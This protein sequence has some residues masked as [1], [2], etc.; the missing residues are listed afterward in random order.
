ML[1][2]NEEKFY[3]VKSGETLSGLAARF[4]LSA[5]RVAAENHLNAP[6]WVGQVLFLP[7]STGVYT[8]QAGDTKTL[9]C[10]SEEAYA[11]CNGTQIFYPGM[12][13]QL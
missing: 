5:Y 4:G 1:R 13:V 8:V 6:L 3:Q 10:G 11:R 9:I 2:R 12:R 7:K